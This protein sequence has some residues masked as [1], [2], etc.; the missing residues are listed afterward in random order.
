MRQLSKLICAVSLRVLAEL[1]FQ[2]R[3]HVAGR[4]GR[5]QEGAHALLAGALVGDG[6]DDRE[7]AVLA[8]GD[9][10]LDAVDHVAVAVLALAVV[11]S[12]EASL[13]TCGSVRQNAPSSSPCASGVQPLLLL[14]VVAVAHQDGVDRA[15][16]DADRGAGAAVAGGDLFQHQ[17]Q[18]HVVEAGAAVLLGHADAVGAQRRQALVRLAA[19]RCARWSQRGGVGPQLLLRERA[20]G[21]ADHFL[22]GGQQHG[23]VSC[24]CYQLERGGRRSRGSA[25]AGGGRAR[26]WCGACRHTLCSTVSGAPAPPMSVCTQ[27]GLDGD[28]GGVAGSRGCAAAHGHVQRRLAGAVQPSRSWIRA[29]DVAHARW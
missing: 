19:G 21:V 14:R 29:A 26:R 6:D 24:G 3:H 13:P 17:R 16:G 1:V 8:A 5:H 4:V 23:C 18:R 10:L 11:R 28:E 9:E 7:L 25:V 27:P 2:P 20:H 22:V 12:A 15:V